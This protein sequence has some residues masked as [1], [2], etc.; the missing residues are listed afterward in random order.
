MLVWL[1]NVDLRVGFPLYLL[2]I[3]PI[4]SDDDAGLIA[5]EVEDKPRQP[6]RFFTCVG[7]GGRPWAYRRIKTM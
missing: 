2:D 4:S 3:L 7:T 5:R 6:R 1:A